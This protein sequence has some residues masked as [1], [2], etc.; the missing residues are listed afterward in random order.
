MH[1]DVDVLAARRERVIDRCSD[2][3]EIVA[4]DD[5]DHRFEER[6]WVELAARA[7]HRRLAVAAVVHHGDRIG[8]DGRAPGQDEE[9]AEVRGLDQGA[10]RHPCDADRAT[11]P[12]IVEI[13]IADVFDHERDFVIREDEVVVGPRHETGAHHW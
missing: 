9:L 6:Q 10:V 5:R 3:G 7:N 1:R 12:R 11:A 8:D 4:V 2:V 13:A